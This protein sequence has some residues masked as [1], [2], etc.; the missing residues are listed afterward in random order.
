MTS[1]NSTVY[2][3]RTQNLLNY[4][5]YKNKL[6]SKIK[7]LRVGLYGRRLV[8]QKISTYFYSLFPLFSFFRRTKIKKRSKKRNMKRII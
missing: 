2:L 4:V 3:K 5:I 7:V 8:C 1:T 6:N